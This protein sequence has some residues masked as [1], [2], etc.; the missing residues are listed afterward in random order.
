MVPPAGDRSRRLPTMSWESIVDGATS[1]PSELDDRST[2]EQ[3][4]PV[5]TATSPLTGPAP[6]DGSIGAAMI[7]SS[8]SAPA[9]PA[10]PIS[11]TADGDAAGDIAFA[12][13][14]FAPLTLDP[15]PPTAPPATPASPVV[16]TPAVSSAMPPAPPQPPLVRAAPVAPIVPALDDAAVVDPP[17]YSAQPGPPVSSSIAPIPSPVVASSELP[18]IVEATPVAVDASFEVLGFADPAA[19]APVVAEQVVAAPVVAAPVVAEQVVAAPVVA[20]PQLPQVQQQ[21]VRP[22]AAAILEEFGVPTS[23]TIPT[24]RHRRKSRRGLKLVLTLVVLGG[25]VAAG[26]VF[27]RPYLSPSDWDATT[28]PYAEAVEAVRGVEYAEA[29]TVSA[30]PTPD[31]TVRLV[32]ELAPDW[33]GDEAMWRALGLLNGAAT[34]SNVAELLVGWQD[35]HYSTTDGQ[36]YQDAGVTGPQAEAAT[37]EAMSAAS[38]DQQYG[39]SRDQ[40]RRTTDDQVLTLAEV[41]RQARTIVAASPFAVAA[42]RVEP[43]VL[44]FVPPL[45]GYRALAPASFAEF[46]TA[47]PDPQNAL[48]SIGMAGPGPLTSEALVPA[49]GPTM[50]GSDAQVSSPR[51]VDRSFWYL[52]FAGYLDSRTAYQAS[53]AVVESAIS[54]ADR[55]GTA[56]VYATFAGG[57][58]EGTATLRSALEAWSAAAPVEF[59]ASVSVLPDGTLQMVSCD[60]GAGFENASRLGVAR[61]LVVW[62]SAELATID[63]VDGTE[64]DLAT[65]WAF[66]EASEVALD[67][68]ALPADTPPDDMAAAARDRVAAVLGPAG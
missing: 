34:Q 3:A 31:Y 15:L 33:T 6:M 40:P 27:G 64:L 1:T 2:G 57:G 51:A 30:E 13:I 10:A 11:S 42:D 37:T 9:D 62:R 29:I 50:V 17:A 55:A 23:T 48:S 58:V 44:A 35:A 18:A 26:I 7:G 38:L 32:G 66:V 20:G 65:T 68:I 46:G 54:M 21:P 14:S 47:S 43:G 24:Q 67:L 41:L 61:E 59:G 12:P 49:P 60:P 19:A 5:P 36:V 28:E 39:W 52:V 16:A 53:E 56:C 22:Q 8:A 45:L 4:V 25:L 63:A